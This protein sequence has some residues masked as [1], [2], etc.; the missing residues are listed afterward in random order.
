MKRFMR[1]IGFFIIGLALTS[2]LLDLKIPEPTNIPSEPS[3]IINAAS[4]GLA[5]TDAP[6]DSSACRRSSVSY[7]FALQP[8]VWR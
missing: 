2:G 8:N 3:C 6:A 1:I 5:T 7:W 4:A